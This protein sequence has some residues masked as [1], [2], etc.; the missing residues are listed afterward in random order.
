MNMFMGKEVCVKTPIGTV[1]GTLVKWY[2]SQHG[3][4]GMLVLKSSNEEKLVVKWNAIYME[5]KQ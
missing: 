5:E 3:G 2:K 1:K 4:Y